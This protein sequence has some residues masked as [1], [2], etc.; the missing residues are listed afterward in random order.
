M[1]RGCRWACRAWRSP[2]ARCRP[3]LEWARNRLQGRV[4]GKPAPVAI[5]EHPDVKRMLLSMKARTE[6]MRALCYFAALELD[7][8]HRGADEARAQLR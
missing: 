2:S 4:A 6:G 3:A 7:K 8:A 5:I 1:R